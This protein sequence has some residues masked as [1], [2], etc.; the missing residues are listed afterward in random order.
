MP[1]FNRQA[2]LDRSLTA[3]RELYTAIEVSI[4]GVG[5]GAPVQA[6]GCVVTT[7]PRK[8][9]ALNPCVP[10]N[11]AVEASHGDV[12]VLTNPE[13]EHREPI[14]PAML[15]DL[16]RLGADGYVTA[17]CWD[18][19][20]MWIAHSSVTGGSD[21]RGYMP[22]GSQF[23]FCAMFHRSLWDKAGGFDEDYRD[24]SHFDDNDW[25]ARLFVAGAMFHHRDDLIVYHHPT[26]TKWPA[27]GWAKNQARFIDKWR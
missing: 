19:R 11:R 9:E 12:I 15:E 23:H 6:P 10:I 7:L 8:T 18:D 13:N 5:S 27:G 22:P 26:G 25:L 24:G 4:C 16:Q 3:Y 17:S 21:G 2:L 1:Y 14:L 20:G